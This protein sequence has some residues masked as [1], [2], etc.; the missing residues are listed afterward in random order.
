MCAF[1]V[2]KILTGQEEMSVL[3]RL[4][5][6]PEAEVI[7]DSTDSTLGATTKT[8]SHA[9]ISSAAKAPSDNN[10]ISP[11][12]APAGRGAPSRNLQ[13]DDSSGSTPIIPL[14]KSFQTDDGSDSTRMIP[15]LK[16]A[17]K[18][19]AP[20]AATYSAPAGRASPSRMLQDD[21]GTGSTP[22]VPD[23]EILQ[24]DD[25]S[26]ST[27]IMPDSAAEGPVVA[28]ATAGLAAPSSAAAEVGSLLP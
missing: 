5:D 24:Q 1:F 18:A 12:T 16:S 28:T 6:R 15:F 4:S 3:A 9:K 20:S 25:G 22:I 11:D 2:Q 10:A 21:D 13:E 27:S 14:V 17:A 23:Q 19:E 7:N 26:D 8:Q